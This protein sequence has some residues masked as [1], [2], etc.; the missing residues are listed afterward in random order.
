MN[1]RFNI[2]IVDD[3]LN[4]I[5]MGIDYLQQNKNYNIVFAT[6]GQQ[7]LERVY[8]NFFDLI[9]LDIDMPVM[10]G[11][12]VCRKLKGNPK[13]A[14]IPIIFLVE[15]HDAD[16]ILN[17]FELGGNDYITK[18]FI[19]PELN[20]RVKTYLELNYYYKS[21]IDKSKQ[22]LVC[23]QK[24][25]KIKFFIDG[26]A[27]ECNNFMTLIPLTLHT[28]KFKLQKQNIDISAYEKYFNAIDTSIDSISNLLNELRDFS[29]HDEM[30]SEIVDLNEVIYVLNKVYVKSMLG[31]IDFN[32]K[33][34][35][36]FVFVMANKLHLEQV[37][38]NL[39]LNAQH[40]IEAKTESD[41]K[42][43]ILINIS[44][45]E[46]PDKNF[47]NFSYVC[48][49]V[50]DN[51]IGMSDDIMKKIFDTHFTTIREK[52]DTKLGLSVCQSIIQS[53]GGYID[54]SSKEGEGTEF[55]VYLKSSKN[56]E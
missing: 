22:L 52:D 21:E 13:T 29:L 54:V 48:I 4:S 20:V 34:N 8:E 27:H 42:G 28:I 12:D 41:E 33:F 1:R 15:K 49:S 17:C 56:V 6:S 53:H 55:K 23:C 10:D 25:E 9:L 46:A 39:V 5:Q 47:T 11:Y 35:T 32:V 45:C 38:F 37:L 44:E 40:A 19:A 18:P 51:G 43:R 2:L 7:A 24:T 14:N 16:S 31:N 26:F 30:D 50:K 36:K 3:D